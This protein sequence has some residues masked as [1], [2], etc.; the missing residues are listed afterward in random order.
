MKML[1]VKATALDAARHDLKV[2]VLAPMVAG[3]AADST[4]KAVEEM[5]AVGVTI[6]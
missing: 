3:V 4:T 5:R 2:R 6:D 1:C